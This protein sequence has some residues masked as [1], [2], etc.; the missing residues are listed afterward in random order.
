M[1]LRPGGVSIESLRKCPGWEG[2]VVGY[3]NGAEV[4]I[5]RAPGMKYRHYSPKARVILIEG[6]LEL[7]FLKNFLEDGRSFGILRTREWKNGELGQIGR[8][9]A[10]ATS[11][12][13][14]NGNG[15]GSA[16]S[17]GAANGKDDEAHHASPS[18]TTT[19]ASPAASHSQIQ[20]SSNV[21]ND[22]SSGSKPITTD[23]WTID[24][25]PDIADV[26]RGL[27]SA[28][29]DLDLKGVAVIF[30]ESVGD[31]DGRGEATAAVMNR[32]RKAAEM[33]LKS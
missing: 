32:L 23:V 30:V 9:A 27:F 6:P 25:G 12:S 14:M 19:S 16:V 29:R 7:E 22:V 1:I 33:E 4:G 24:L 5:P 26:A 28:L 3:K 10:V 31:D 18:L 8:S 11:S 17:T 20:L 2:V 21:N 15:I 13:N